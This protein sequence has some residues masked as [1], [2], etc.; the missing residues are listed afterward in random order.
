MSK[1]NCFKIME[2]KCVYVFHCAYPYNTMAFT[3]KVKHGALIAL[4]NAYC[5]VIKFGICLS[6]L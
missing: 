1:I 5:K 4:M 2:Q 3:P 6:C